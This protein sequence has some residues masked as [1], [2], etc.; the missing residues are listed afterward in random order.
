MMLTGAVF[1]AASFGLINL[2]P[3][4]FQPPRAILLLISIIAITGGL[5]IITRRETKWNNFLGGVLLFALAVIGGW[6]AV[7]GPEERISG[8][9]AFLPPEANVVLAR[10]VFGMGGIICLTLSIFAVHRGLKAE[11]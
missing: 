2:D 7:F 1:L 9:L 10:T 11:Q 8:G 6:A 3:S 5:L 4:T